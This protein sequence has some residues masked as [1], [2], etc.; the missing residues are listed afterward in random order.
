MDM[1]TVLQ[2]WQAIP[3]VYPK[4]PMPKNMLF[5][6]LQKQVTYNVMAWRKGR[7]IRP[8][9]FGLHCVLIGGELQVSNKLKI[10]LGKHRYCP[11]R[12]CILPCPENNSL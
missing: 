2:Q 4:T 5:C 10:L 9:L 6:V 1:G 12:T 8:Q 7:N 11:Q 3:T